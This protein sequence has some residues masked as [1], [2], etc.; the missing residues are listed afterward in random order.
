LVAV[1]LAKIA[2]VVTTIFVRESSIP[3]EIKQ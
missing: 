3:P 1:T 2:A